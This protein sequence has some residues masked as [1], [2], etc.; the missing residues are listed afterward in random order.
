MGVL[1]NSDYSL[2]NFSEKDLIIHI[3]S[4][5]GEKIFDLTILVK[6]NKE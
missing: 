5:V 4:N 3:S 1:I 6:K 2:S